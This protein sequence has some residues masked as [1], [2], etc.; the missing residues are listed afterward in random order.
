MHFDMYAKLN[1]AH[2]DIGKMKKLRNKTKN[3][4]LLIPGETWRKKQLLRPLGVARSQK[5]I[6]FPCNTIKFQNCHRVN[7]GSN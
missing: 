4:K 6:Q 2:C 3:V 1:E 5:T 7:Y